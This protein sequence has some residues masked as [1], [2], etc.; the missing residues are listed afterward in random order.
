MNHIISSENNGFVKGRY[1]T[2]GIIQVHE[3]IHLMHNKRTPTMVV[4]MDMKKAYDKVSW[5]FLDMVLAKL[6]FGKV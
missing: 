6:G 4:K 1:I 3:V 5:I 2:Y